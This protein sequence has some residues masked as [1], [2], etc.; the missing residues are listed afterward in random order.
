MIEGPRND[1]K[2]CDLKILVTGASGFIGSH[3]CSRLCDEGAEVHATS[4][5]DRKSERAGPI[6]WMADMAD[7][8]VARRV[9]ADVKPDI[10]YH[11]AGSVGAGPDLGLVVPAYH[12]LLTS[13]VNLLVAGTEIGCHRVILTGSCTEPLPYRTQS[14]SP[15]ALAKWAASAYGRMFHSLFQAPVVI[16]RPFMVYGP[17][18]ASSKLIP[19]VILSLLAGISPKISSGKRRADWIYVSDV[20]DA[21]VS[22]ATAPGIEGTTIDLGSGSLVTIRGIVERLTAIVGSDAKPM[23]GAVPDRPDENEIVADT[24]CASATLGWVQKTA[25]ENGLRQTV[26]WYK[27]IV[28]SQE[29]RQLN[30]TGFDAGR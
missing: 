1:H 3:L 29:A 28:R 23:F 2:F 24:A 30:A 20:I 9:L 7:L 15:Y 18:Q 13:T 17:A 14:S 26:E 5:L 21:F 6:W 11:L 22:A 27:E 16:L 4:R 8:S 25:L 12:S 19:S 10:V